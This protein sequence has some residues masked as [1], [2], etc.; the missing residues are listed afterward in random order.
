MSSTI[1]GELKRHKMSGTLTYLVAI[2]FS[3]ASTQWLEMPGITSFDNVVGW[4]I[5][6]WVLVR[7][8][9]GVNLVVVDISV[10]GSTNT[11][12]S[13]LAQVGGGISVQARA[14]DGEVI[15]TVTSGSGLYDTGNWVHMIGTC[16]Y[17]NKTLVAYINGNLVVV[18]GAAFTAGST[19]NTPSKSAAIGADASLTS[20]FFEGLIEDVR[21]YTRIL[22]VN[23]AATLYATLGKDVI[24][25]NLANR[26]PLNEGPDGTIPSGNGSII[27]IGPAPYNATPANGP[28]F[29]PGI[30]T[31]RRR[32]RHSIGSR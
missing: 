11:R 29:A 27:D 8:Y 24:V 4:S 12:A 5:A 10:G 9:N 7:A 13:I 23:E 17:T 1:M 6:A 21:L 18:G 22:T 25:Q 3:A 20:N 16:D 30:T 14:G 28:F 26:Y 2:D 32:T 31:Q 15:R 19:S